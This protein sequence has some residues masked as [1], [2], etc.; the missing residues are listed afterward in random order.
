MDDPRLDAVYDKAAELGI[1]V[2]LHS[3]DPEEF[4]QPP[5]RFNWWLGHIDP[6]KTRAD[7]R[8]YWHIIGQVP[9]RETLH[10]E[11]EN[12]LRKHPNTTFIL[13]HMGWLSRQLPL[14]ADILERYPRVQLDLSAAVGELARSPAESAA[15]LNHY[16]GR[17]LFGSDM[18]LGP[19]SLERGIG[20]VTTYFRLLE[21]DAMQ[22]AEAPRRG[23]NVSGLKLPAPTL[24]KIY[25]ENAAKLLEDR[26]HAN[27]P[28]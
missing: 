21:T 17:V 20:H 12:V 9:S 1:P 5:N 10:R 3:S 18:G 25:Y 19:A 16:A 24:K 7:D 26:S 27:G 23:W 14:L 22:P 8:G 13:V 2:A 15:F 4:F 6:A 28:D 11:R